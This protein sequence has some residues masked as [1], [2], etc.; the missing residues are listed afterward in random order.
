MIECGAGR[1]ELNALDR[2]VDVPV[3]L[4]AFYPRKSS[5]SHRE[6]RGHRDDVAFSV[7]CCSSDGCAGNGNQGTVLSLCSLCPLWLKPFLGL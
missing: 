5:S 1:G 2:I 4:L 6:H 7:I 3:S